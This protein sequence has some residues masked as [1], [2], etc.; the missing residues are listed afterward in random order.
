MTIKALWHRSKIADDGEIPLVGCA[1]RRDDVQ[2]AA[3]RAVPADGV[4]M[5]HGADAS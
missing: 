4:T 1:S 2:G 5:G 3:R